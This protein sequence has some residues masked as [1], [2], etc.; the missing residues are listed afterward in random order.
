MQPTEFGDLTESESL[1]WKAFAR[2]AWVDLRSGDPEIDP[3]ANV[4]GWGAQRAIRAEVIRAL[5]L[6]AEETKPGHFP[7]LRLRGARVIG[8]LDLMGATVPYAFVCEYCSFDDE[9]RLVEAS[10]K[11]VRFVDCALPYL[12][13]T[14]LNAEGIVNL[15]RSAVRDVLRLD[16]ARIV[17]ELS[18]REAVVG[19]GTDEFCLSADG[20]IAYGD[21]ACTDLVCRGAGQMR[22]LRT[23]GSLDLT[24]A[25]FEPRSPGLGLTLGNATV[26]GRLKAEG[27][28][29]AGELRLR[30]AR[31][32]GSVNL[33]G[34]RL[35]NPGGSALGAGGLTVEGG[36]WCTGLRANGEVRL[37]GARLSANV[38]LADAELTNP[39]GLA[40]NLDHATLGA[41]EARRLTVAAGQISL[42]STQIAATLDLQD[43]RLDGGSGDTPAFVAD[44]ASIGGTVKLDRV[45]V[46]GEMDMRTCKIGGRVL[47]ASARLYNP[48][49]V[50]LRFTRT[51]VA[52]D[53][54][55][56]GMTATGRVRFTGAQIGRRLELRG[57]RLSNP[58]GTALDA[59]ALTVAELSLRPAEPVQGTVNLSHARI[60]RLIDDPQLWPEHLN[61][62][63]L[64][65]RALEPRLPA[66]ERLDW[67]ARYPREYQSQP[68]E[69]LAAHY[70]ST[71]QSAE[72]SHVLYAREQRRRKAKSGLGRIGSLIQEITVGYGYRPWRAVAWLAFLLAAGSI[73][74][75][76]TPPP[77]LQ[78]G[79]APHFIP[80]IY[81]LDLL[82]PV[83]DLGQ[84][85]AFNPSGFGQWFSYV[86]IACGWVLATTIA[87][88]VA[89]VLSRR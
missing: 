1:L 38:A 72:A 85:H 50:A 5:L 59:R 84:K 17:G 32:A 73:V 30:H 31:V 14:R 51:E 69:Q 37:P 9:V 3:V 42:V 80:A 87:A 2:G 74:Y 64:T 46:T 67:L 21:V 12:N 18:L 41:L 77:P 45:R 75:A 82:L 15:Y 28:D 27:L 49:A 70:T 35:D 86:L 10:M 33:T 79:A 60:E 13:A 88:G 63:G 19:P 55:C 81:T 57:A 4:E 34:A 24:G 39:G 44:T 6:G 52:A 23:D 53:V 56:D 20:L 61:L 76:V 8:R 78:G 66:R 54:F 47:M 22:G 29:V 65:Y 43:A 71:G 7:A 26:S 68:Y 48:G 40:L 36:L 11:T 58:A 62:D 16:G 89:R 83:V 25:R